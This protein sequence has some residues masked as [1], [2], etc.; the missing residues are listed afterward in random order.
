MMMQKSTLYL[1]GILAVIA[2]AAYIVTSQNNNSSYPT[3][4]AGNAGNTGTVSGDV[5]KVVIGVKNY[6]YYPNTIKVQAGKPVSITLDSS[7]RGCLRD[8]TIRSFGI[9]KYL[10]TPQDTVEFTPTQKGTY[11]F[12][13]S[14]GMGTGTL[15]VE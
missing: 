3:G 4:N 6:N 2:I 8:F 15:V 14:M 13:C 5:Q 10:K 12:A 1:L 7:V 11:T 9:K